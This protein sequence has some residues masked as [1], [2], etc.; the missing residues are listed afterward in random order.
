MNLLFSDAC[1]VQSFSSALPATLLMRGVSKIF[2]DRMFDIIDACAAPGNKTTQL[3]EHIRSN[4]IVFA[5]EK[6]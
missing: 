4:G 6:N 5:F 3:S 2:K 1:V